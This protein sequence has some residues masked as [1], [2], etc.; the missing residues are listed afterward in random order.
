MIFFTDR[1]LNASV[2][3]NNYEPVTFDELVQNNRQCK[4]SHIA[5]PRTREAP[6]LQQ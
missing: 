2:E 3:V 4:E 5:S 6:P 1:I